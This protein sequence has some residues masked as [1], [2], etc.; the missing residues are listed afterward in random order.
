MQR[1]Q[2]TDLDAEQ[3]AICRMPLPMCRA[4]ACK[5]GRLPCPCPQSCVLR[6]DEEERRG[7]G[8]GILLWP[9]AIV[10]ALCAIYVI[11][12]SLQ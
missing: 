6:E 4:D 2:T 12:R 11:V 8:A 3:R 9:A 5:S 10:V 7:D 1:I